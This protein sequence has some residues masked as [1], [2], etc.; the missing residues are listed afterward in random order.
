MRDTPSVSLTSGAK[1]QRRLDV[2]T[3]AQE[4]VVKAA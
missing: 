4:H 3:R 1:L 2:N